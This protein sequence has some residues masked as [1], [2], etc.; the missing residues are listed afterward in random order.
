[1]LATTLWFRRREGSQFRQ[2]YARW[3]YGS[4]TGGGDFNAGVN[5]NSSERAPAGNILTTSRDG[6]SCV[7]IG[8]CV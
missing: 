4:L 1:L 5:K 6:K 3:L 8:A 7:F 2:F